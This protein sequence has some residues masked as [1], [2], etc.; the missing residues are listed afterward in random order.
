MDKDIRK[1]RKSIEQRKKMRGKLPEKDPSEQQIFSPLPQE[2]E[3]HGY[4]PVFTETPSSNVRMNNKMFS[5]V[6]KG[7]CSVVLFFGAAVLLESDQTYLSGAKEWTNRA[8]TDEFPFAKVNLW[9]QET[10]GSPLAFS[11]DRGQGSEGPYEN[12]AMPV[13]GNVQETFQVN[14]KGIMISPQEES[15]VSVMHDG[16][17]IFSG[18]DRETNQTVVVQHADGSKTTYGNL[19]EIDVHLYQFVSANQRIGKF[20]PNQANE[21][22]YFSIE[23]D[24]QYID[25]VQVIQV[26]DI[27]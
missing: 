21:S 19:S 25:P 1:V 15:I 11:S 6:M 12:V 18:N 24:D 14:G 5:F 26:D 23:K 22:V 7:I 3:K 9:Y 2:E 8:L 13:M 16:V 17:I 10:F 4:Y 27:P 20:T